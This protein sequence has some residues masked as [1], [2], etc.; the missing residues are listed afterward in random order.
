MVDGPAVE[1]PSTGEADAV[2]ARDPTLDGLTAGG[3]D[4]IAGLEAKGPSTNGSATGVTIT[5]F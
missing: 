5:L 1:V 3:S 2:G 4:A